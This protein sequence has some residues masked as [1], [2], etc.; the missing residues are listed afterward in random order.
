MDDAEVVPGEVPEGRS[1]VD[2]PS[3]ESIICLGSQERWRSTIHRK[4]TGK[5]RPFSS[6]NDFLNAHIC[7]DWGLGCS[8]SFLG[9]VD[10][11]A[12]MV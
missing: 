5:L 1:I 3:V 10:R 6:S 7:V 2:R 4:H 11:E 12:M 8:H 9:S